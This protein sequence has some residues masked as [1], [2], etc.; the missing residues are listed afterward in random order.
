LTL[1]NIVKE[2]S[3]KLQGYALGATDTNSPLAGYNLA[4]NG[5]LDDVLLQQARDLVNRIKHDPYINWKNDWKVSNNASYPQAGFYSPDR[6][7]TKF[8]RTPMQWS[9][10]H[11]FF[12]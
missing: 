5:A 1:P 9:Q 6:D 11:I 8:S 3:P 10:K 2:F 4:E 12:T 7:P